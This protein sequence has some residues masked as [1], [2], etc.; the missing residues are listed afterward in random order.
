MKKKNNNQTVKQTNEIQ[1]KKISTNACPDNDILQKQDGKYGLLN[2]NGDVEYHEQRKKESEN[3]LFS[4]PKI[5]IPFGL[6]DK[7]KEIIEDALE[8][9]ESIDS[10]LD[11]IFWRTC[12]DQSQWN[13]FYECGD[14]VHPLV[15]HID[16]IDES[17][18]EIEEN[19]QSFF[20]S[21]Y[22]EI[23]KW[24]HSQGIPKYSHNEDQLF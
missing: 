5:L 24:A 19:I 12:Y 13:S 15:E 1:C 20:E 21:N 8:G 6:S 14:L 11:N 9:Y 10:M 3:F 18:V 22:E 23:E 4:D 7:K 16:C 2:Y 17:L